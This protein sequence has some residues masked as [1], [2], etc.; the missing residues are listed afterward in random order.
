M[1]PQNVLAGKWPLAGYACHGQGALLLT[2]A[3]PAQEM[4][5]G[6]LVHG[7]L[8]EVG[9]EHS[10][11]GCA[12]GAQDAPRLLRAGAWPPGSIAPSCAEVLELSPGQ[13]SCE[14]GHGAKG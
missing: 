14:G 13:P 12:F 11:A 10:F 8:F 4:A 6:K 1:N 3:G 9:R 7:L 2:Q 5:T